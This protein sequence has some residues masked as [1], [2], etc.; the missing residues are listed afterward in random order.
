[1]PPKKRTPRP[2]P[3]K[4]ERA[5]RFLAEAGYS[6]SQVAAFP[7]PMG[8]PCADLNT[9]GSSAISQATAYLPMAGG[10]KGAMYQSLHPD[11]RTPL[12]IP[13]R[14]WWRELRF[15]SARVILWVA[16]TLRKLAWRIAP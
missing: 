13:W 1:M 14:K 15:Q 9:T 5:D 6:T 16:R 7:R 12:V 11:R 2:L 8:V 10:E 4:K 3:T